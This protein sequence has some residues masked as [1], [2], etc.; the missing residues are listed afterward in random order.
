AGR[1]A[2][3]RAAARAPHA[4]QLTGE[5]WTRLT[6]AER[7]IYLNGFLAGAAAEQ[8]RATAAAAGREGDSAAV[9]SA[10]IAALR[11]GHALHF[12]FAPPVY[13]SQVD[14]FYWWADHRATPI[15]DAMIFFNAEMLKQQA[16]A[17][18]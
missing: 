11:A 15:V 5:Y 6:T 3:P 4:A 13:S 10:A 9:S 8:A 2:A 1:A 18:P 16:R 14:D 17:K 12:P 7:Q